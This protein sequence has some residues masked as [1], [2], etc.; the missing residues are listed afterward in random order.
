MCGDLKVKRLN[1][2]FD[3]RLERLRKDLQK[4]ERFA[5]FGIGEC[6]KNVMEHFEDMLPRID[7]FIVSDIDP[8]VTF[9]GKPVIRFE[10]Y[11]KPDVPILIAVSELYQDEIISKVKTRYKEYIPITNYFRKN[12]STYEMYENATEDEFYQYL[13]EWHIDTYGKVGE[14]EEIFSEIKNR[15]R[16]IPEKRKIVFVVDTI[17]VRIARI[18]KELAR[19]GFSVRILN[20]WN[21]EYAGDC[22]VDGIAGVEVISCH[23]VEE[24]LYEALQVNPCAYYLES[25]FARPFTPA[26]IIRFK[27]IYG[28]VIF[29]PYDV[30]NRSFPGYPDKVYQIERYALENADGVIWRYFAKEFYENE[31]GFHM[32]GKHL[33]MMDGCENK[34]AAFRKD[35][36]V[37]KICC[38]P[39]HIKYLLSKKD[40]KYIRTALLEEIFE[41]F[42]GRSDWLFHVYTWRASKEE[43]EILQ[44]LEMKY[45]NFSVFIHVDHQKLMEE[46]TKYDYGAWIMK[47]TEIPISPEYAV[48]GD[49]ASD[50]VGEVS[51]RF[52][53]CNKFFEYI[54]CGLPVITTY[55][56]QL[57]D[58]FFQQGILMRMTVDDLDID[59]LKEKKG[60]FS[61][62]I[63]EAK[64]KYDIKNNVDAF[65][66]FL[67]IL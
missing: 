3:I 47:G 31:L 28:K 32:I 24:Y 17:T 57:A 8:G 15:Y 30:L 29:S 33:L 49:G 26:I 54:E 51:I 46:L 21:R 38:V 64:K 13:S 1:N 39:T 56:I 66:K 53:I 42:E 62:A 60:S 7:A 45:E 35:D 27:K 10:E 19:R 58:E 41:K 14:T 63:N 5:V 65:V 16:R 6:S 55:P 37:V 9:H 4:I 67:D 22:E 52:G 11:K 25:P 18:V 40:D 59:V 50:K 48:W 12:E 23:S 43:R 34:K 20:G 44:K 36:D 61:S 2:I